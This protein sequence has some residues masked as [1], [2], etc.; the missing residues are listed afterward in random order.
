MYL[1][2]SSLRMLLP[3][4]A[5]FVAVATH[6]ETPTAVAVKSRDE[7]TV[8]TEAQIAAFRPYTQFAR[9]VGCA[10]RDALAWNCG[11]PCSALPEFQPTASG[12]DGDAEQFWFVGYHPPLNSVIVSHQGTDFTKL[13]PVLTVIDILLTPLNKALFPNAPEGVLIHDGFRKEHE[14]TAGRI[15]AAVKSTLADHPDASVA[16]TGGSLG[17]ALSEIEALFLRSQLPNTTHVKFVGYS[18]PRVGNQAFADYADATLED[19]SRIN[20]KHDPVPILPLYLWPFSEYRH[21]SGEIHINDENQWLACPGQESEAT[22]CTNNEMQSFL[23]WVPKD[24]TGP[25]DGLM[26]N[27]CD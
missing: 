15:L 20:N 14:L 19:L 8:L 11:G 3:V 9:A 7:V 6:A 27:T 26:I 23:D 10:G 17:A 5:L 12:G 2:G 1:T 13:F 21:P 16:C 25:F 24:H 22:G 4:L 18:G